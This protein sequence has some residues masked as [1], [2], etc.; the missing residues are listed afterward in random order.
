MKISS[1]NSFRNFKGTVKRNK[2]QLTREIVCCPKATRESIIGNINTLKYRLETQT[3][4]C[5]TFNIKFFH[6]FES[7]SKYS[8]FRYYGTIQVT[9]ESGNR[10]AKDFLVAKSFP[11]H[12]SEL[13]YVADGQTIWEEGFKDI[14]DQLLAQKPCPNKTCEKVNNQKAVQEAQLPAEI[15]AIYDKIN[16]GEER[17]I[18][19]KKDVAF[20]IYEATRHF[21]KEIEEALV[22]NF[23]TLL[24]RMEEGTS[25]DKKYKITT[26][27]GLNHEFS[28]FMRFNIRVKALVDENEYFEK[29]IALSDTKNL[30]KCTVSGQDVWDKLF[31][32]LTEKVLHDG[33][34]HLP[35]QEDSS[36]RDIFNRLD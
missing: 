1:V 7:D 9:D 20:S 17:I 15:K 24:Q 23:N 30:T 8:P 22:G 28:V 16:D 6:G 14:T 4:D 34:N 25:K 35:F 36:M 2:E 33:Y 21:P 26:K 18:F 5:K 13:S 10:T 32:P 3:P 12:P 19:D 29:S 27:G 11:R 31:Q